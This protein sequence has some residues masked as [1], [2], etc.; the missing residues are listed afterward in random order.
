MKEGSEY[1][2]KVHKFGGYPFESRKRSRGHELHPEK[3]Y[4]DACDDRAEPQIMDLFQ[5]TRRLL[6]LSL[7]R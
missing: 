3:K 2:E 6:K 5:Y 7:Q 4:F 1:S